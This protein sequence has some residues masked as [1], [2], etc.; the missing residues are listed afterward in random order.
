MPVLTPLEIG[1][2]TAP[3]DQGLV[4]VE[5]EI[6]WSFQ[7]DFGPYLKQI[8]EDRGLSQRRLAHRV[9]V[10]HTYLVRLE[11]GDKVKA[12]PWDLIERIA[13]E[14]GRDPREVLTRAGFFYSVPDAEPSEDPVRRDFEALV[15]N[16]DLR[17]TGLTAEVLPYIPRQVQRQWLEF[18]DKLLAQRDP[19]GMVKAILRDRRDRDRS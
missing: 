8:R 9:G 14:L 15:L 12:P 3:G 2:S 7:K 18:T 4:P 17:P 19:A 11:A 10:S 6:L 5:A 16:A 1:Y 13:D